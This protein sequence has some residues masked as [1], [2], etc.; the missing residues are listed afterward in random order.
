M[1]KTA[2]VRKPTE[3]TSAAIYHCTEKATGREFYVVKSDSSNE[4]YQVTWNAAAQEWTCPCPSYKPCKHIRAVVEVIRARQEQARAVIAQAVAVV[5]E[6]DRLDAETR[7]LLDAK[8]R[9]AWHSCDGCGR[10]T[11]Q[12][13]CAHCLGYGA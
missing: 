10:Q 6:S 7:A 2:T 12:S 1:N 9:G 5:E 3:I 8:A 4:Y 13:L 11:L